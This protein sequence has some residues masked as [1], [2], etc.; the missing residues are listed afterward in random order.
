MSE[1]FTSPAV[2]AALERLG[3]RLDPD[4]LARLE[5]LGCEVV[6]WNERVNLTA[7][8][9]PAEIAI[10]HVLDSLAVLPII[11]ERVGETGE[12]LVDIGAGPGY[13]GIPIAIVCAML[14]VTLVEATGKKVDFLKHAIATLDLANARA[15]HG[16]AEDLGHEAAF[17]GGATFATARAVGRVTVLSELTLPLLE[18]GGWAF[19]WKTRAAATDEV[20]EARPALATL[21]G[22]VED[23]VDVSV[24]GLL[25]SRVCVVLRKI[26][27]TPEGYPRRPGVPQHKPLGITSAS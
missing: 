11:R 24:P 3:I 17:R 7:I 5:T 12:R 6:A 1:Q 25:E 4:Q 26:A 2:I 15:I 22:V 8:T 14:D 13:P 27:P 20:R 9:D 18:V 21:G 19:L 16:R 23:V 10:K